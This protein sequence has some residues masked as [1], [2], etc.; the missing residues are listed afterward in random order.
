M[1][2]ITDLVTNILHFLSL[3]SVL[4]CIEVA[5]FITGI[6][7]FQKWLAHDKQKN[8][9]LIFYAYCI[10]LACTQIFYLPSI[11][12]ILNYSTPLII[13]F[14]IIIHQ[15]TLQKSYIALQK[16]YPQE[17][18]SDQWLK[19]LIQVSLNALNCQTDIIFVVEGKDNLK[20]LI[21]SPCTFYAEF[22]KDIIEIILQKHIISP[23]TF[24]WLTYTG[25][26][27][28]INNTWK[29]ELEKEFI[30][31]NNTID[32]PWKLYG[33]HISLKTDAL[34]FKINFL[35]RNFDVILKGRIVEQIGVEQLFTI[36]EKYIQEINHKSTLPVPRNAKKA[37]PTVKEL[38]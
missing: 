6:Y 18:T 20:N 9:I 21:I 25:K 29:Y 27:V 14:F 7:Y 4:D 19:E 33:A 10:I 12:L 28:A 1:K 38:H 2:F 30:S 5:F 32:S 22:K 23:H 35:T 26:C 31:T 24:V 3:Y 37:Q 15:N 11:S 13:L 16:I 34:L 8:L 36:L 17:K